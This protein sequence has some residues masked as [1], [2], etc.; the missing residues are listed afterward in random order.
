MP[1]CLR[2]GQNNRMIQW[3]FDTDFG[4]RVEV[5]GCQK[6]GICHVVTQGDRPA[7]GIEDLPDGRYV[8][9]GTTQKGRRSLATRDEEEPDA[10]T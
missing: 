5:S 6:C 3:G 9:M 4:G 2:C 7:D 1:P 8:A 10:K